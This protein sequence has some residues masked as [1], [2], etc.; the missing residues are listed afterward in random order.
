VT[1][2]EVDL[3]AQYFGEACAALVHVVVTA[4]AA[5]Q[6][7]PGCLAGDFEGGRDGRDAVCLRND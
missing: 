6:F 2:E 7:G 4:R 5:E 1:V 3:C